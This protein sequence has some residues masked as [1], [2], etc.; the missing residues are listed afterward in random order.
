MCRVDPG[1]VE[2]SLQSIHES[3]EGE[4][5][6]RVRSW[7]SSVPDQRWGEDIVLGSQ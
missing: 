1:L 7:C 3:A 5:G 6:A 2:L 4:G